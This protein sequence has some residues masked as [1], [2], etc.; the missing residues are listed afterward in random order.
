MKTGE[1]VHGVVWQS[2]W[3]LL[4][5]NNEASSMENTELTTDLSRKHPYAFH[6]II[7]NTCCEAGVS[8]CEGFVD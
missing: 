1:E 8:G 3:M 2:I 6:E 4:S 5:F 7:R